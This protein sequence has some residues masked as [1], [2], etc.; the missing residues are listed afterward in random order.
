MSLKL[1][2]RTVIV[3][4]SPE[5][6]KIVLQKHDIDFCSRSAPS[7]VKYAKH[8][9]VSVVWLP[10]ENQWRKLRKICKEQMSV[11]RLDTCQGLRREKVQKLLVHLKQCCE[12]G[13]AVDIG[14]SAFTTT[15]N[16]MSASLFSV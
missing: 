7:S 1:G 5:L 4:S 10:V 16:L 3:V 11:S 12:T 15:L 2:S 6:A 9:K 14:E 13:R 8:D